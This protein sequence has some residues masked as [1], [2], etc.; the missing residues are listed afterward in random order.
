MTRETDPNNSFIGDFQNTGGVVDLPETDGTLL[1]SELD[2]QIRDAKQMVYNT[3]K[4]CD[5]EVTATH[6]ELNYVDGAEQ[7]LAL[8]AKGQTSTGLA[9]A[10]GDA[11]NP[12]TYTLTTGE[13][14][15]LADGDHFT[16]QVDEASTDNPQLIVDA[17]AAK[18]LVKKDGSNLSANDLSANQITEV[19]Y[20]L[21]QDYFQVIGG[22]VTTIS[23]GFTTSSYLSPGVDSFTVPDN[24]FEISIHIM[25]GGGGGTG[26]GG[27]NG[28]CGGGGG[29]GY[30]R[31]TDMAVNPG[32]TMTVTVGVGGLGGMGSNGSGGGTSSVIYNAW[33]LSANG[34]A[35]GE[36]TDGG[37]AGGLGGTALAS[38]TPPFPDNITKTG[39]NGG[40]GSTTNGHFGGG[41]GSAAGNDGFGQNGEAGGA[42][43][44]RGGDGSLD[45]QSCSGACTPDDATNPPE[46]YDA[47][48]G[49][50]GP[51]AQND[52]NGGNAG[53]FGGGGGGTGNGF[54]TGGNGSEGFVVFVY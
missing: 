32:D 53:L 16:F 47:N 6:T 12:N 28:S 41:G 54:G 37:R 23:A 27:A 14:H 7:N 50:G 31:V 3:F 34:G 35:G 9:V 1:V 46:A 39:G 24:V 25:G 15:T 40:D 17:N 13:S 26:G 52:D 20:V 29:G 36:T 21:A 19:V 51:G 4:S 43:A 48:S 30:I 38:G 42:S 33:T 44:T 49:G 5:D 8:W 11:G 10:T 2:D 18:N 22:I 45:A